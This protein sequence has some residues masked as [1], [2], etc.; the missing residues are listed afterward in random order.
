MIAFIKKF[1]S[2]V[3]VFSLNTAFELSVFL[4]IYVNYCLFLRVFCCS[5]TTVCFYTTRLI[6]VTDVSWAKRYGYGEAV[7]LIFVVIDWHQIA[8]THTHTL[9]RLKVVKLCF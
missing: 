9:C 2:I 6:I 4:Y 7:V 1:E 3:F 8:I 5:K